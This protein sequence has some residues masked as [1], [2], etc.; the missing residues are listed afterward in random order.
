VSVHS[1]ARDTGAVNTVDAC[2]ARA[3]GFRSLSSLDGAPVT[4]V[5]VVAA[6]NLHGAEVLVSLV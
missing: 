2:N 3:R 6:R 1:G 4:P 5:D